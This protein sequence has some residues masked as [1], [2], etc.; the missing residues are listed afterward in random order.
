VREIELKEARKNERKEGREITGRV[1]K[2]V[3]LV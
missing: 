1:I 2:S 3:S